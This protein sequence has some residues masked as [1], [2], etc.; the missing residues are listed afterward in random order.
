MIKSA[1]ISYTGGKKLDVDQIALNLVQIPQ[2]WDS[3]V[4]AENRD[5]MPERY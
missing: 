1:F 3:S 4:I 2:G 5:E